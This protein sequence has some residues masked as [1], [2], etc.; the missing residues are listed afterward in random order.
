MRF[1][2]HITAVI[3]IAVLGTSCTTARAPSA[4]FPASV[5][6]SSF[7]AHALAE[8]SFDCVKV[9]SDPSDSFEMRKQMIRAAQSEIILS[10]YQLRPD[11]KPLQLLALLRDA[12][13]RGVKVRILLDDFTTK[14]SK[15]SIQHLRDRGVDIRIFNPVRIKKPRQFDRRMHDKYTVV[16]GKFLIVGGRNLTNSYFI[17]N[18]ETKNSFYDIDAA[19]IGTAASEAQSH[20]NE[21]WL[22]KW[23]DTDKPKSSLEKDAEV[24]SLRLDA[25]RLAM[26]NESDTKLDLAAIEAQVC[27]SIAFHASHPDLSQRER[28][29]ETLYVDEI[30]NAKVSVEIVNPYIILTSRLKRAVKEAVRRGVKVRI[31]TNS[32]GSNDIFLAHSA[33]LNLRPKFI[34]WGVE[35]YEF[36]HAQTIHSKV[37]VFDRKRVI[38]GSFNL[39]PRSSKIN[40][41]NL[42]ISDDPRA[43]DPVALFFDETMGLSARI[44]KD[45]KPDG[46]DRRHPGTRFKKRLLN[47]LFR[48]SIAPLFRSKL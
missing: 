19:F 46:F 3:F 23:V 10:Y 30:T 28:N 48:F 9:L 29:L 37:A 8:T 25:E 16:D 39:D 47:V 44:A 5:T 26:T 43:V 24:F 18:I 33:Y 36:I 6:A 17:N 2:Q 13:D 1:L 12:A 20:F 14:F 35:V 4:R 7:E 32:L 11:Q 21:R 31:V 27:E 40:T 42:V 41:E 38:I 22:T 34:R 15:A 45:G